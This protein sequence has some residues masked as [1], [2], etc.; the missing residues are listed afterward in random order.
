MHGS[1]LEGPSNGRP[2]VVRIGLDHRPVSVRVRVAY[3]VGRLGRTQ[4]SI[5]MPVAEPRHLVALDESFVSVVAH[6]L[7]HPQPRL[8]HRFAGIGRQ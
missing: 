6:D 2:E 5:Q 7:E 4:E 3:H 8:A 1:L